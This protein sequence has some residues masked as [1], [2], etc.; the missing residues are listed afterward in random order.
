MHLT[1][2]GSIALLC[3]IVG[4]GQQ[5]STPAVVNDTVHTPAT[6]G[7]ANITAGQLR[8]LRWIEGSWVGSGDGQAAF[9]E[10]YRFVDDSTLAVEG[11]TDSTGRVPSDTTFFAL[12]A[13][14]FGNKGSS[15][16]AAAHLN[17]TEVRFIPVTARNEFT[18]RYVS[19]NE[20]T[21]LLKWPATPERPARERIYHMRRASF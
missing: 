9:A 13:G 3:V 8:Q 2:L 14:R 6:T 4:C 12:R 1:R 17:A 11:F 20:W 16:W 18:W 7:A 5:G 10:R 21:A 19:A 15:E